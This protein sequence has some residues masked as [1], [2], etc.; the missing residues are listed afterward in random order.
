MRSKLG[1]MTGILLAQ[2]VIVAIY[3]FGAGTREDEAKPFVLVDVA[4]VDAIVIGERG[5]DGDT[6][7]DL[8]R[9]EDGW[10]VAKIDADDSKIDNILQ[11]IAALEAAWPVATSGA[12]AERFEV[13][14]ESHQRRVQLLDS[15]QDTLAEFFLGT[16][17]GYQR[18]HARAADSEDIYSVALSNFELAADVDSWMDKALIASSDAPSRVQVVML[19]TLSELNPAAESAD[20]EEST[21]VEPETGFPPLDAVLS[22]SDEGWLINGEAADQDAAQTYANRFN[23]LRVLGVADAAAA[24]EHIATVDLT[25]GKGDLQFVFSRKDSESN[26]YVV[27]SSRVAGAYRVAAYIAEQIMMTD[28]DFAV[29]PETT[30]PALPS[31]D[32][33]RELERE[34]SAVEG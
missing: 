5:D 23:T 22:Q 32:V 8:E 34:K 12:S 11:K 28:S 4:E 33:I 14:E 27:K 18:V 25:D 29:Q 7:V 21:V 1:L 3:W 13:T 19:G 16:S 30:E 15:D 9:G 6:T 2:F 17:P 26:D 10:L 24:V 20:D 31:E